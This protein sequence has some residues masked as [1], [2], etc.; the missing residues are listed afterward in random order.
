MYRILLLIFLC[1]A[2]TVTAG[3]VKPRTVKKV[4]SEQQSAQ[5]RIKEN[6]RKLNANTRETQRNLNEL[7]VLN[8]EISATNKEIATVRSHID[9]INTGIRHTTDSIAGLNA[10]IDEITRTYAKALRSLQGSQPVMDKLGFIFSSESFGKAYARMRYVDEFARWRKR[11]VA[12]ITAARED[13]ARQRTH[14]DSLNA[15]KQISLRHLNTSQDKLVRKQQATDKVVKKL[16]SEQ[17][18]LKAAIRN[19]EKQM[20]QLENELKRLEREEAQRRKREEAARAA[21]SKTSRQKTSKGGRNS[22]KAGSQ[23][24]DEEAVSGISAADR[25]LTGGFES[26]KGRLLLPVSGSYTIVRKFGSTHHPEINNIETRNTG[27]DI[28]V[29][30]GTPARCI[31]DGDVS[32]VMWQGAGIATILI[33]HGNYRSVYQYVA[34]PRVKTGDKVKTNQVIGTVA[35]HADYSKRPVLHFEIRKGRTPLSPMQWVR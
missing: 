9:S 10:R 18:R 14:L 24:S 7:H 11:K 31:Y 20:Q 21:R 17:G 30:A 28:L 35:P 22:A 19:Q 32:A 13:M 33:R 3:P 26:N 6:T 5:K 34:S 16:K 27:I 8:A 2:G 12:A 29:G 25:K 15:S 23:K 1:F 4:K